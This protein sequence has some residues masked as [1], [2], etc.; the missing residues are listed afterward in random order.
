MAHVDDPN[1]RFVLTGGPGVG[2]TSVIE[3]LRA[4]GSHCFDD[5]ARSIIRE[6]R[7]VGLPPRTAPAAFALEILRREVV[8]WAAAPLDVGPVFHERGVVDALAM[9]QHTGALETSAIVDRLERHPYRTPVFLFPPWREIFVQDAE[10]DQ[11][12]EHVERAHEAV[13]RY[14]EQVGYRIVEV[15][16]GPVEV[17]ALFVI[18]HAHGALEV[19]D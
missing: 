2:K 3:V 7:A 8:T 17:R 15:P 16:R 6:R 12:F 18:E 11:D 5:A 9:A 10:R 13:R 1:P 4:R 14:Y 19:G